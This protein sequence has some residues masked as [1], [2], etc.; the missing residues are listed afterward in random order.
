MSDAILFRRRAAGFTLIEIVMVILIT[1]LLS[2][3]G[4]HIMRFSI[5]NTFYLPNQVQTDLAAA[6]ALETIVEGDTSTVRGLR[7]CKA[8]TALAANQVNV[9]D[10]DDVALQFRLNTANHRLYRKIGAAAETLV[11]YAMPANVNF[12]GGGAGGALFTYYDGSNPE[13]VTAVPADVRRI[14]I[15][16]VAQ[17]GAGSV[18][19]FE[20]SSAQSTSIK[21]NRFV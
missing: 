8:V 7:F 3:A 16:L 13:V 14:Q 18:D 20:G 17:Q 2:V 19:S 10:Q 5:Q 4:V 6:E 1:A 15:N 9:T 12:S 21:V 11:P